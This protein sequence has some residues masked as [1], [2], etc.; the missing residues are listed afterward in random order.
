MG[1]SGAGSS[2][3]R[4]GRH[5]VRDRTRH[6]TSLDDVSPRHGDT[7]ARPRRC[8]GCSLAILGGMLLT[9]GRCAAL[10]AMARATS[11]SRRTRVAPTDHVDSCERPEL[12]GRRAALD[13]EVHHDDDDAGLPPSGDLTATAA[14]TTVARSAGRRGSLRAPRRASAAARSP[15]ARIEASSPCVATAG[16]S[17]PSRARDL[18]DEAIDGPW[19]RP[20]PPSDEAAGYVDGPERTTAGASPAVVRSSRARP[21]ALPRSRPSRRRASPAPSPRACPR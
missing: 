4:H 3:T 9:V 7:M 1:T 13:H 17:E 10:A 11:S 8:D 15:R 21:R 6:A 16:Q 12:G 20:A 19:L 5:G 14:S 18:L 2:V